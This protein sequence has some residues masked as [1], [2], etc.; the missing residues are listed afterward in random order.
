MSP[1]NAMMNWDPDG[2]G[3]LGDVI[4]LGGRMGF[5]NQSACTSFQNLAVWDGKD[6]SSLLATPNA[7]VR[8]LA[9]YQGKL[10]IA[11][12]FTA[13]G[14]WNP[15]YVARFGE[16]SWEQPLNGLNAPVHALCVY[17]DELIAGGMFTEEGTI[18]VPHI[19]AWNGASWRA[20]GA[21]MDGTV[22]AVTA[23]NDQLIAGGDFLLADGQPAS[24]L[25]QDSTLTGSRC[26][27][28][29]D[30]TAKDGRR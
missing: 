25:A 9:V 26:S 7:A 8:A 10:H 16:S 20:L 23:F 4:V 19:A 2:D 15:A 28:L 12:D 11:G 24:R 29:G 3:P 30:G 27:S 22:R 21:G 13:I 18:A 1:V 17:H 14:N 6:Y 5:G